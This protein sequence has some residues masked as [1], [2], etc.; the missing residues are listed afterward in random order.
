MKGF[1]WKMGDGK[2]YQNLKGN[3][4]RYTGKIKGLFSLP[5][6]FLLNRNIHLNTR[7]PLL[8]SPPKYPL[9]RQVPI[10]GISVFTV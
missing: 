3:K 5:A 1:D 8:P 4:N 9:I 6:T 2:E 10:I 7:R